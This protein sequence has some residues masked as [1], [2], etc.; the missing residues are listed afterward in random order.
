MPPNV[1]FQIQDA[2][3]EWPWEN[4]SFDFIHVRFLIGNILDWSRFY[5]EAFRCCKPSGW[6]EH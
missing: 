1:E 2:N 6:I 3:L 4:K 5:R